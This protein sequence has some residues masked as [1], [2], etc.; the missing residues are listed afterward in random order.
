M[1]VYPKVFSPIVVEESSESS[2]SEEVEAKIATAIRTAPQEPIVQKGIRYFKLQAP[3]PANPS[4]SSE[5]QE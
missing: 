3:V 4:E 1:S 2:D 5:D